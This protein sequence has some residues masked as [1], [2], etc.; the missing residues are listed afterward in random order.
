MTAGGGEGVNDEPCGAVAMIG[1]EKERGFV[2]LQCW[3]LEKQK[4]II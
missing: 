3:K 2:E 4:E 1:N